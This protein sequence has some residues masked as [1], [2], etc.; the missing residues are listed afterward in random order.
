MSHCPWVSIQV[1]ADVRWDW[2]M[3]CPRVTGDTNWKDLPSVVERVCR[4]G[5]VWEGSANQAAYPQKGVALRS[6]PWR[7]EPGESEHWPVSG[8]PWWRVWPTASL[9]VPL[10]RAPEVGAACAGPHGG[11]KGATPCP[12]QSSLRAHVPYTVCSVPGLLVRVTLGDF[13]IQNDPGKKAV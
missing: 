4:R 3:P 9:M 10:A 11:R 5:G 8:A 7:S 13:A 12:R 6:R 1:K 2:S